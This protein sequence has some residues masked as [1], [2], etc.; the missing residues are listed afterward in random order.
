MNGKREKKMKQRMQK[1]LQKNLKKLYLLCGCFLMLLFAGYPAKVS[2]AY[3]PTAWD[4]LEIGLRRGSDIVSIRDGYMRVFY[5]EKK[6]TVGIE[7]YDDNFQIKSKREIP[8]ELP[9]WG[10]FYAG[11][12]GYYLIEG[13]ANEAE[14]NAAEVIRVIRYDFN[15][16]RVGSARII[17]N[18][19]IFGGK[20]RYPFDYGC[21]EVTENNGKLYIVTGHEGYVDPLFQQGHQGFLMVEVDTATMTGRIVAGDQWHSFAQYI[22]SDGKDLYVLEQSEGSRYMKLS[23]YNATTFEETSL[24]IFQYGGTQD[25]AWA[26][27]CYASVDGMAMSANNIL[28]LGTSIDQSQYNSVSANTP[29]NI[30]L[31]VT[32]KANFSEGATSVKWL[33]S[34]R[35]NG[36]RFKGARITKVN[37]NRFMI[38]WEEV[39]SK[40]AASLDDSLSSG[41]LHYLFVDGNGNKIS[42]EYTA[43]T[44]FSDC[45]PIVKGS[46]VVYYASNGNM[47][48][49]YS[50][51]SVSGK[52]NKRIY[53]V[54]GEQSTWDFKDG[55]LTISGSGDMEVGSENS[56]A[57][58]FL[59]DHAEKIVIG[60]GITRIPEKAFAYMD[61]LKEVV[62]E[63]GLTSI[64]KEAFA[65][66]EKLEKITIPSSVTNIGEDVLWTGWES[67]G[68]H[69]TSATICAPQGSYAIK[70][71]K[72]HGISYQISL[73]EA[74]VSGIK[75]SY[76]YTGKKLT[77]KVTVKIGKKTL[78]ENRD[79]TVSYKKNKKV[80]TASV[81]IKGCGTYDGTIVHKFKIVSSAKGTK[82][83][84]KKTGTVYTVT[85]GSTVALKEQKNT[86]KT[87]VTVPSRIKIKGV[88][89][90]VTS[91]A[92]NA[93]KNNRKLK[94]VVIPK[95]VTSIGA[96]AFEGCSALKSVELGGQV[97]SIGSRAFYNCKAMTSLTIRTSKLSAKNVGSKAFTNVGRKELRKLKVKVPAQKLSSYKKM[98][99][100]KGLSSKAKVL[101]IK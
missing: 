46:K 39:G 38:S 34:Y 5:K 48:N 10:G 26:I 60:R 24:N 30:Y 99:R 80:G 57:W 45:Q 97:K 78:K 63:P 19:E 42:T 74:K 1:K 32:P 83:T 14:N 11:S 28:C 91:I 43:A 85:G 44:S 4:N 52:V 25:S 88:T 90:Q 81:I 89:Y 50:I 18:P 31:T 36:K 16:R 2:A 96:G 73:L 55:K 22:K 59:G 15:W 62:I 82:L 9:V 56:S 92:K 21:V 27:P 67:G 95:S 37:D 6:N 68:R 3:V 51:D 23:K 41:I 54:A 70:Y 13:Q 53:R 76:T 12:N 77:P 100:S 93:F 64:G 75:K 49:F 33:T 71:A 86:S 98:L 87:T 35:G 20:V 69:L 8:M 17:S 101:K 7:Y 84:D 40:G 47:V 79:F 65:H 72:K 29:Y 66:C 61:N 58:A 94:K